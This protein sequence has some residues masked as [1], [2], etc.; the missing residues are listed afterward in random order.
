MSYTISA[1]LFTAT[2]MDQP[3]CAQQAAGVRQ[4]DVQE[5]SPVQVIAGPFPPLVMNVGEDIVAW[6]VRMIPVNVWSNSKTDKFF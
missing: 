1:L 6:Y 4:Q 3:V 2:R 5:D